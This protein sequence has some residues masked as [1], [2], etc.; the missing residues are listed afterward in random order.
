MLL[1]TPPHR[2]AAAQTP[3]QAGQGYRGRVRAAV[4][5][6]PRHPRGWR[7]EPRRVHKIRRRRFTSLQ[8]AAG[9]LPGRAKPVQAR[10]GGPDRRRPQRR[11]SR[12]STNLVPNNQTT[13]RGRHRCRQ[14]R[15]RARGPRVRKP[16]T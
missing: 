6:L 5:R 12:F 16:E 2:R 13:L 4:M 3:E 7:F 15:R 11:P 1:R 10:V 9:Q 8:A 14:L